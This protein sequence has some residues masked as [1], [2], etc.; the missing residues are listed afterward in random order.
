MPL[1]LKSTIAHVLL[2]RFSA[3]AVLFLLAA[4]VVPGSSPGAE[5]MYVKPSTEVPIRSGQGTEYKI[6][7]VV[8]DGLRV[9]ILEEDDP[10]VKVRTEGGT[11][12]WMLAR[13]LS[14]TP[15]LSEVVASLRTEKTELAE[16]SEELTHQL[17]ELS[18]AHSQCSKELNACIIARDDILSRYEMLQEDTA[19]VTGIKKQLAEARE[20]AREIRDKLTSVQQ[21]NANL[22]KTIGL[23]W[24]LAGG[25]VLLTGW[26]LG[27]LFG[28][29]RGKKSSLY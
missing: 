1:P 22:R 14:S 4:V 15:P 23:K 26:I 28:K 21:A 16:R 8:P 9:E 29:S 2:P 6:L 17:D 18:I 11:E 19:D 10:W 7:S 25:G 5:K 20:D 13:Y 24:F 27:L 3:A 12:G